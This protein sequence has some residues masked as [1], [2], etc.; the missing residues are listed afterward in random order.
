MSGS[1]TITVNYTR[2]K[3]IFIVRKFCSA[4]PAPITPDIGLPGYAGD[5]IFLKF[6]SEMAEKPRA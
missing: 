1:S 5:T 2:S 4:V 6:R 3:R